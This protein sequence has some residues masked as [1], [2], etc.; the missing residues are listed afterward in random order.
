M[1]KN[2]SG[3]K[4]NRKYK[5]DSQAVKRELIFKDVDQDYGIV[6]KMLGNMRL[7][8]QSMN[9]Q[10]MQCLIRGKL[11]KKVWISVG[12]VVL[13]SI[14]DFQEDKADVIHKYTL[15]E[16]RLLRSYNEIPESFIVNASIATTDVQSEEVVEFNDDEDNIDVDDI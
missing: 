1:T 16:S 13:I 8:A 4:S 3:G 10:K 2:K 11:K 7:E 5:N 15:D 14:R 6:T 12:D 9:G